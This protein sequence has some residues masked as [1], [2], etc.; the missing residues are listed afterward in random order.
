M[1]I[2]FNNKGVLKEQFDD[3]GTVL[4]A[5]GATNFR[6]FAYFEGLNPNNDS[7]INYSQALIRFKRPDLEGSE[8]PSLFM[9]PA[10]ITF[11]GTGYN[12]HFFHNGNDY[13]GFIFDFAKIKDNGAFVKM[14]DTP[15]LWQ[16]SITLLNSTTGSTV[17][18]LTTFNVAG[19]VSDADEEETQLTYEAMVQNIADQLTY[20]AL[21]SQVITIINALSDIADWSVYED[22]RLFYARDTGYYYAADS[23]SDTGYSLT[24][25]TGMLGSKGAIARYEVPTVLGPVIWPTFGELFDLFERRTFTIHFQNWDYICQLQTIPGSANSNKVQATAFYMPEHKL[26]IA[27]MLKT[28][29]FEDLVVSSRYLVELADKNYV[30]D[31]FYI[32]TEDLNIGDNHII[33]GTG[34]SMLGDNDGLYINGAEWLDLYGDSINIHGETVNI[35]GQIV[36]IQGNVDFEGNYVSYK[37][38]EVATKQDIEDLGSVLVYCGTKSVDQL[39]GTAMSGNVTTKKAGDTYNISDSGILTDGN[40]E[41]NAGDNVAWTGSVWDKL[42]APIDLSDYALRPVVSVTSEADATLEDNSI[43][44]LKPLN[45]DAYTLR[46]PSEIEEGYASCANFETSAVTTLTIVNNSAYTIDYIFNGQSINAS[47]LNYMLPKNAIVESM[48]EFNGFNLR[49]LFKGNKL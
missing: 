42:T 10:K 7:Y 31:N 37:G 32:K 20:Y 19:A 6:I 5:V 39:N 14:L 47:D 28:D 26:Y 46:I 3:Y 23:S 13:Y 2:Y 30:Q 17:T 18:G 40:V 35:D 45:K 1:I 36:N 22:G 16:A 38:H 33:F 12:S 44:V 49:F 29:N 34:A 8:Y 27:E 15:G 9:Q 25:K 24:E 41:V 21:N 4:P 48:I 11:N 43:H